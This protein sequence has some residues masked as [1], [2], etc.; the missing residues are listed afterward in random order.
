M[1]ESYKYLSGGGNLYNPPLPSNGVR[2]APHMN[3]PYGKD[4]PPEVPI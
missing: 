4:F 2:V 1:A 3:N